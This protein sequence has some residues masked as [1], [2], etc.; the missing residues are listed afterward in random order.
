ML[1]CDQSS[2]FPL[3]IEHISIQNKNKSKSRKKTK[4]NKYVLNV[5][6]KRVITK[7]R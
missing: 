4:S 3:V 7:K 1:A 5:N 6:K 2:T